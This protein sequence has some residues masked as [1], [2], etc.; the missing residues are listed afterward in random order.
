MTPSTEPSIMRAYP[1]RKIGIGGIERGEEIMSIYW[2]ILL[3]VA[4]AYSI[5]VSAC[6][7][8][9][10]IYDSGQKRRQLLVVWSFPLLGP[11][12]AH[13]MLRQSESDGDLSQD[14]LKGTEAPR[15]FERRSTAGT[16]PSAF[17]T[18]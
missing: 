4:L 1:N 7:I 5:Y 10:D 3:G 14:G 18:D 13:G 12:L 6:V 9:S 11:F 2:W 17:A 15:A 16:T 8:R